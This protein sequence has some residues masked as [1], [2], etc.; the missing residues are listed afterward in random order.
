MPGRHIPGRNGLAALRLLKLIEFLTELLQHRN[1]QHRCNQS[2]DEQYRQERHHPNR[3]DDQS[4]KADQLLKPGWA[5]AP[6][7][8]LHALQS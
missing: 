8:L 1:Q 5:T 7:Q 3:D 6:G 4:S 2:D